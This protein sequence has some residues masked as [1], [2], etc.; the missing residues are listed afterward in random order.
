VKNASEKAL[1]FNRTAERRRG[2]NGTDPWDRSCEASREFALAVRCEWFLDV[3]GKSTMMV[4]APLTFAKVAVTV[5]CPSAIA[6]TT[7]AAFTVTTAS[8]ADAHRELA[9]RS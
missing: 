3:H 4:L 9:V 6:V 8:L 1:A 7:P 2:D 5:V